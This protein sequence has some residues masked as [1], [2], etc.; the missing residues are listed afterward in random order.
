V[1]RKRLGRGLDALLSHESSPRNDS[2]AE[3][4][5]QQAEVAI[6]DVVRGR[7]QPRR[8][9]DEASLEELAASIKAQGLMQP[10]VVRPRPQ[11][12][13]ELIAGER[14][15]RASQLAG[16]THVPAVVKDVSDEQASAMALI[17]NIQREDLNPLEEAFALQRLKDE[18]ELT[19]Q[20]VADAIGKSRVAVTNLLRLLNLA[21]PV[22][23]MLQ[24]GALEMG[25]ARALLSLTSIDQE[26]LAHEV[27]NRQLSVRQT[28]ALVRQRLARAAA[29]H[30]G[31]GQGGNGASA[32]VRDRDTARL[33]QE[34]SERIGAPVQIAHSAS[35][36][37]QLV[38][39]YTNLDELQGILK[40]LR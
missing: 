31:S 22:R 37:G 36:R 18:F 29:G 15:W 17:E 7:Y 35:G 39:S 11:G 28:E 6:V 9:F 40:H 14:R 1:S 38:I 26:R 20:Q 21:P 19:Q 24:S 16:L 10:I 2:A 33:E 27:A 3:Q 32:A 23:D 25:H 13:Y 8:E 4:T 12:G 5:A 30:G 34:L